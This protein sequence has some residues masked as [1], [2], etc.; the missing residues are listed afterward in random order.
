MISSFK[1]KVF[2]SEKNTEIK[3]L[4]G[5]RLFVGCYGGYLFEF[6]IIQK[7]TVHDLGQILDDDI[8]SMAKTP[9]NKS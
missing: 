6:S 8:T 3:N 1:K 9:D 5:V 7:K 2:K 4:Q